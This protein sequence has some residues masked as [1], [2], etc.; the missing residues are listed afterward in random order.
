MKPTS[1]VGNLVFTYTTCRAFWPLRRPS[2]GGSVL[3]PRWLK[4]DGTEAMLVK[5]KVKARFL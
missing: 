3:A 4:A 1:F 2:R 5:R